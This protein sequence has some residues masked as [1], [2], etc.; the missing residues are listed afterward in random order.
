M[1]TTKPRIT[2]TL[3][4]DVY[5]TV[6]GMAEAQGCSM[7]A[8]VSELLIAVNPAQK[9]VLKAVQRAAAMTASERA[10]T[11]ERLER[12]EQQLSMALEP[13]L[14]LLDDAGAAPQPPHSNTGVTTP[15]PPTRTDPKKPAN[16]RRTK[17]T[18][19]TDAEWQ[20]EQRKIREARDMGLL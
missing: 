3:E 11:V 7:S 6:K 14:G 16:P 8:V 10:K 15:N 12:A 4:N 5:E 9:R 17:A 1:A 13:V 18:A 19:I 2:V 20:K